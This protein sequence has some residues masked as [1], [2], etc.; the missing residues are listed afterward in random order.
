MSK[1][2]AIRGIEKNG[3]EWAGNLF[4]LK[5]GFE[6]LARIRLYKTGDTWETEITDEGSGLVN[7]AQWWERPDGDDVAVWG[8]GYYLKLL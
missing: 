7:T 5:N 2:Y 3:D 8:G 6:K 1:K 4:N